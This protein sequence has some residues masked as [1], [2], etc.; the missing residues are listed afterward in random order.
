MAARGTMK[1]VAFGAALS[2]FVLPVRAIA[3]EPRAIKLRLPPTVVAANGNVE[4]CLYTSIPATAAF[5][6]GRWEIVQQGLRRDF[7]AV[8]FLVYHYTGDHAAEFARDAGR[9]VASRACL[10]L[11]SADRDR[12]QLIVSNPLTRS[13]NAF[14]PG[15]VLPLAPAPDAPGGPPAA[16][17]LLIDV[18]LSNV[19]TRRRRVAARVVLRP[20][21]AGTVKRELKPIFERTAES[22]L[23]VA[24][25]TLSST[26]SSTAAWNAANPGAPL[27]DAWGPGLPTRGSPAPAGDACVVF[28]TGAFHRHGRF[29]AVDAVAAD[30]SVVPQPQGVTNPIE[31]ARRHLFGAVD[32]SD[33]GTLTFQRPRLVRIGERL[34]YACWHDNGVARPVR[35]GCE[36]VAGVPPGQPAVVSGGGPAKPCTTSGANPSECPPMDGAH[37]GRTFTGRCVPARL[38]AGTGLDDEVCVLS[39]VYYDAVAGAPVGAECDVAS[40]PV[41]R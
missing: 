22:A 21:S 4:L 12:R 13:R 10:G 3:R 19:S 25:R 35:L 18:N 5:D 40:L 29:L 30:G 31:P 6:L 28:V 7:T 33:P 8:H 17:G 14:P 32:Y 24:P 15:L 16:I 2:L 39:G 34:R 20:A 27:L 26:E 23:D 41:L 1:R 11:G 9:V 38:V 37:P 36:E